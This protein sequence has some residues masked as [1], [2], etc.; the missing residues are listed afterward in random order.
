MSQEDL[1]K[2]SLIASFKG[3]TTGGVLTTQSAKGCS[4]TRTSTGVVPIT[5]DP[6]PSFDPN[7]DSTQSDFDF[8]L[9]S[10]QVQ[11]SI[12]DT[13]GTVKT[14]TLTSMVTP[15]LPIEAIFGVKIYRLF[16]Q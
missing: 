3:N 13:S 7:V 16:P 14:I 12:A 4:A 6:S 2:R 1:V 10:S 15:T 9:Q 5:L 11:M 8:Y